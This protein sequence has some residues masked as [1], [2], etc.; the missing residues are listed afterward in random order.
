VRYLLV[1]LSNTAI[2]FAVIWIALRG[3][4]LGNIA[5]NIAGYAVAFLWS[6]AVNRRWTF[7][8]RGEIGAG[9]IRYVLVCALAYLANLT[10]VMWLDRRSSGAGLLIQLAGMATYTVLGFLGSRYFA[11]PANG[12]MPAAVDACGNPASSRCGCRAP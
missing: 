6:F 10:V 2:G 7:A 4:G 12:A 8:H 3:F 11:F 1:G 9:L 5:A